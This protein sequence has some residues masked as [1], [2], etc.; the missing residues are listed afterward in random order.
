[1]NA[2]PSKIHFERVSKLDHVFNMD[3]KP[4]RLQLDREQF[5][6]EMGFDKYE[7]RQ[8][9]V[10]SLLKNNPICQD[11]LSKLG[12]D[13]AQSPIWEERMLMGFSLSGKRIFRVSHNLT[14][15]LSSTDF[16]LELD[17]LELPFDAFYIAWDHS[18][19]HISHEDGTLYPL[20]GCY[21]HKTDE[22][23]MSGGSK[24][25]WTQINF[26]WVAKGYKE[27]ELGITI[28]DNLY[29]IQIDMDKWR[30][31]LSSENFGPLKQLSG[32]DYS[33]R[34][35]GDALEMS[36]KN[37]DL[38][39][40]IN[41]AINTV[42]YITSDTP[43]LKNIPSPSSQ[44]KLKNVG[45]KKL[46]RL[47]RKKSRA[48]DIPYTEVGGAIQIPGGPSSHASSKGNL[49]L[50]VR[51]QVRGHWRMQPYGEG[52]LK[53]KRIWIRPHFKGPDAAQVVHREFE[54]K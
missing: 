9:N 27:T 47:E 3:G 48:S 17:Q 15:L 52:L 35:T 31:E 18:D 2:I 50:R 38:R 10:W 33:D 4:I 46:G 40:L 7:P 13:A 16:K 24:R 14:E 41:L 20:E 28:D 26:M 11:M 8:V 29:H 43:D 51:F 32:G 19:I 39:G 53:T 1:M 12:A 49:H 42:L 36:T 6:S 25:N 45:V 44:I 23:D 22:V 21:I 5:Y 37:T 54:V 30:G 34:D